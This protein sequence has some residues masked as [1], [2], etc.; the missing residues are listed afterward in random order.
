MLYYQVVWDS[1]V[2]LVFSGW[3]TLVC[4]SNCLSGCP[5]N[6]FGGDLGGYGGVWVDMGDMGVYG[7]VLG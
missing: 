5:S 3:N 6:C 2:S 7:D 1:G 4:T